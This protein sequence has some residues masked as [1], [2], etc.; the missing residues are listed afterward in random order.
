MHSVDAS[1]IM[2]LGPGAEVPTGSLQAIEQ[3]H[4]PACEVIVV[5]DRNASA[6]PKIRKLFPGVRVIHCRG[7]GS[8]AARNTGAAAARAGNFA[9]LDAGCLPERNWLSEGIRVLTAETN[10]GAVGGRIFQ[11]LRNHPTGTELCEVVMYLDQ[12]HYVEELGFAA[13]AN[14]FVSREVFEQVGGFDPRFQSG[15]DWALSQKLK[16]HG[17]SVRYADSAMVVHPPRSRF[18]DFVA[19]ERR[20]QKGHMMLTRQREMQHVRFPLRSIIPPLR[21]MAVLWR[22]TSARSLEERVRAQ[23]AYLIVHYLLFLDRLWLG[24]RRGALDV[25]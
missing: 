20:L 10:C 22:R 12:Q 6:E 17:F 9:F 15:G 1:I 13:T 8:Y 24:A 23:M 5:I 2:P 3:L 18:A 7:R 11:P 25:D 19:K 21:R 4:S 16:R 14:C